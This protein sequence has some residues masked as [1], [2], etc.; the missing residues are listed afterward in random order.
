MLMTC[1]S[2]SLAWKCRAIASTNGWA[3]RHRSEKSIGNSMCLKCGIATSI[4]WSRLSRCF[5]IGIG[6]S[7]DRRIGQADIVS[8]AHVDCVSMRAGA[9]QNVGFSCQSHIHVDW[10]AAQGSERR[11]RSYLAL[12]EPAAQFLFRG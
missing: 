7:N 2:V 8:N 10:Q 1:S 4:S 11:H 9:K 3:P 12:R 6:E 5:L